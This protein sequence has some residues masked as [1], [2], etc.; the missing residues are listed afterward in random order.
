MIYLGTIA[1]P[2]DSGQRAMFL[3]AYV[4]GAEDKCREVG[5]KKRFPQGVVEIYGRPQMLPRSS[6]RWEMNRLWGRAVVR[7]VRQT[8]NPRRPLP[9]SSPQWLWFLRAVDW[10]E[11]MHL[12]LKGESLLV[13]SRRAGV[14]PGDA[15]RTSLRI[16]GS[17]LTAWVMFLDGVA[18]PGLVFDDPLAPHFAQKASELT[19]RRQRVER[20]KLDE[21]HRAELETLSE[22]EAASGLRRRGV[23]EREV[24]TA[25]VDAEM[26]SIGVNPEDYPYP[27]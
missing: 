20:Q 12:G 16:S 22:V 27:L 1:N 23:T 7:Q 4:L 11:V 24:R 9:V 6:L 26:K 17:R 3:S 5:A 14:T 2:P 10:R 8:P 15:L 19:R 25:E 21:Q 18:L 13:H